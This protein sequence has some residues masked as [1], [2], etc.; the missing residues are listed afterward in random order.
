MQCGVRGDNL[1][2]GHSRVYR[3]QTVKNEDAAPHGSWFNVG[4]LSSSTRLSEHYHK[5]MNGL[6]AHMICFVLVALSSISHTFDH[7]PFETS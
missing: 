3:E 7:I 5:K 4:S 2:S 6:L 1:V